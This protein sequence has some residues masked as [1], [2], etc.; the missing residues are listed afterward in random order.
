MFFNRNLHF[1]KQ[2]WPEIARNIEQAQPYQT[3]TATLLKAKADT[4]IINNI[5]LTGAYDRKHEAQVQCEELPDDAKHVFLYGP[6]LGDIQTHLLQRDTLLQLHVCV[7]NYAVFSVVLSY[8][9]QPWLSDP[10]VILHDMN[11]LK[12]VY[13]P[14]VVA[15]AELQLAANEAIKLRD[16]LWLELDHE[17]VQQKHLGNF[18]AINCQVLANSAVISKDHDVASLFDQANGSKALIIAAGPSLEHHYETLKAIYKRENRPLVIAADVTI[19]VF[20]SLDLVPDYVVYIDPDY[21][22]H[23]QQYDLTHFSN[24]RLVYFPRMATTDLLHWPGKRY[25]AYS[26]STLFDEIK[27]QLPRASLF[28]GGSVLHA[29]TDLAVKMGVSELYFLGADFGYVNERTHAFWENNTLMPAGINSANTFVLN[30]NNEPIPTHA[31]FRGYLRELERYIEAHPSVHFFNTSLVG[32]HIDGAPF[33]K[34]FAEK[35]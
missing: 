21:K 32:A 35:I 17:F 28:S 22:H 14:F 5:Q 30:G 19:P 7:L 13:S 2:R 27:Q 15:P 34:D 4:L 10:R 11:S 23:F 1:I 24:S 3:L 20:N 26:D 29:A 9:D 6:A 31:N 25:C 16:R 18:D 12:D 8:F 33:A